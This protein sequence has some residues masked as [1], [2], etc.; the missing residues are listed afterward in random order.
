MSEWGGM[1]GM[2]RIFENKPKNGRNLRLDGCCLLDSAEQQV[3]VL[4]LCTRNFCT[5]LG[6]SKHP[7]YYFHASTPHPI[8]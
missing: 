7:C 4:L 8:N 3:N 1:E 5:G 6:K 2:M